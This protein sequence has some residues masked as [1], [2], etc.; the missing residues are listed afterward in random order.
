MSCGGGNNAANG[1][2]RNGSPKWERTILQLSKSV[3][4][5]PAH[6]Q[7]LQTKPASTQL[8]SDAKTNLH[9]ICRFTTQLLDGTGLIIRENVLHIDCFKT[10]SSL[11][12]HILRHGPR[13]TNCCKISRAPLVYCETL[14]V[15]SQSF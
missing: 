4:D 14:Q 3:P 9:R 13:Q 8:S 15:S 10:S 7:P 12:E 5:W 6:P 1:I 11:G 2:L